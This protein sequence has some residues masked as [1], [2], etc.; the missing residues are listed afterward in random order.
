MSLPCTPTGS[1]A[2]DLDVFACPLDGLRLIEASAGTGKT[3]NICG[4]YLRLLL[5]KNLDVPQILVVT[6]TNA[7]TA[8]LRARIRRR[9]VDVLAYLRHGTIDG[10]RFV[11][12]L[13]AAVAGNAGVDRQQMLTRVDAAL[14]AFDEAAVFTI[15]G[16]CQRALADT[17]FAAG[18][19]L[20]LELLPDEQPLRLEA[21][22]DFWRRHV[23]GA[24]IS[25]ALADYL[26][27]RQDCPQSWAR[28]LGRQLAKSHSRVIW[29]AE[30]DRVAAA[31]HPGA[32]TTAF[33]RA[34][35]LWDGDGAEP[36]VALLA[37]LAVLNA[38]SYR[39]D[40][41]RT[42]ALAWT[43]WL[44]QGEPLGAPDPE[45]SKARLFAAHYIAD[46]T[47]RNQTAPEHPF[48]AAA[49]DLLAQHKSLTQ[50]LQLARLRLLRL[51][52][53]EAGTALRQQKRRQRVLSFD[54]MLYNVDAALASGD[55][56]W[57]AGALRERYPVALIDEF[58]DTDPLQHAIF[59]RIYDAGDGRP[60]AP[61]FL[62]GDPKQA[63]Y[64]FR[65][66][67]LHTYLAARRQ[68]GTPYTLRH[69]QRSTAPLIDAC[70]ALFAVNPAS[71]ILPGLN[72][73]PVSAGDKPRPLLTDHSD[74]GDHGDQGHE[75]PAALRV[76]WL[77]ND[78]GQYLWRAEAKEQVLRATAG[79]VVRLLRAAQAG[80][81]T[82]GERPLAPGDMAIL[83][84]SH[85]QGRL[86]RDALLQ[87]GVGS[88]E[89]SQHSIFHTPDAEDL[90][91]VLLA[92]IEPTRP[93]LLYRAL[94]TELMGFDAVAVAA[95]AAD[96]AQLLRTMACF[97][98]YRDLW[99]RRGFGVML[100]AWI[101]SEAVTFRLLARSD[102]ERRLTNLLHLGELL[103]HV[104]ADHPA[105][106]ALLRWLNSQRR[107]DGADEVAQLRLE[108]DRNL[109]QIV[110]IHKA[111]GLEY[112]IVFCPFLWDG[113]QSSFAEAEGSEYHDDDGQ[114]VID[115]RLE[116]AAA[117]AADIKRRRR[118]EK[119]AEFMRLV[120]VALTRAAQRC[121]LVAG[122]YAT[123]A[124]GKR[125]ATQGNRSLLNW[126]VA[127]KDLS[128]AEW[129]SHKLPASQIEADWRSL[130]TAAG[131]QLS[132][133]D[134]PGE[135]AIALSAVQLAPES[136]SAR[137]PPAR[138]PA[139]WRIGSFSS[140]QHGAESEVSASDHDGRAG[141]AI[142]A[143]SGSQAALKTAT[144]SAANEI[145]PDD[146]RLFP[147][148]PAAGDCVHAL[149]EL[150]DFA[151]PRRWPDAIAAALAAYPQALPGQTASAS[152]SRLVRMLHRLLADVLATPL[153]GG[154]ILS[155]LSPRQRLVELEFNLPT[156]GITPQVLNGWLKAHGYALP[157]LGF[158]PLA[159]YL[160]GFIDL[161]FC[162]ANRYYVLDWKSNH[163]GYA[164]TDYGQQ[165]LAMAM[166][167]H[168]YHLQCLIYCVAL[169]RYLRR[170]VVDYDYE[171]H[172]G[173]AHYLFVR[174]VRPDWHEVAADGEAIVCGV[175]HH[176]PPKSTLESLDA[177]LAGASL[178]TRA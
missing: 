30:L 68:A 61:L 35:Q 76:W 106:D 88:V 20:S 80:R 94:A 49:S 16:F 130:A 85:A 132:L 69:N 131:P 31:I 26:A 155:S 119:D 167:V 64:S 75:T 91:R 74:A 84:K 122:C 129:L 40:S 38:T 145:L 47:R 65:N 23:A 27:Q 107:D 55:T 46:K 173:G 72:Y 146:I 99:L 172:F 149:F 3:W 125:S 22:S 56:P 114:P 115:F 17:P 53:D 171:R 29:P 141:L 112:G 148:G 151:D 120:Y 13:V 178:A 32:L 2:I 113:H 8:E 175:Y 126:L 12:S 60:A 77:P 18:L 89:L 161:V 128:Y 25:P 133:T 79:E 170:R 21:V 176:R 5:E 116:V 168:G 57:L 109:V 52:F 54:D 48:F 144:D 58:Q 59:Q 44:S 157:R 154:I 100:R 70:N 66:A 83:V 153:P 102:G 143:G 110:T 103:Q 150:V 45:S 63:I 39:E 137:P 104:A 108:S 81:I 73:E 163:L 6:F 71:F 62:V 165:P 87:V 51:M 9:L 118:E 92:I 4:L 117:T 50:A 1:A 28:L 147:R 14:H 139:A 19:P 160:K 43:A 37:G 98:G 162:H 97:S 142:P 10:D 156:A 42:G 7:A 67:D 134:L 174:G 124:F 164:A 159:G 96:E 33:Q 24:R 34:R 111:K 135:A 138:I 101:D 36:M 90:E 78:G 121:Y 123:P 15:H 95:L 158:Q 127:G 11:A 152:T 169:H 41:I 86:L 82:L 166:S 93:P 136:L 177:L 140:L 105:P